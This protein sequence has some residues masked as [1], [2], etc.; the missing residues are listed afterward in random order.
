LSVRFHVQPRKDKGRLKVIHAKAAFDLTVS[1]INRI[2]DSHM[3]KIEEEIQKAISSGKF[4]CYFSFVCIDFNTV[5][6]IIKELKEN[7]YMSDHVFHGRV[8]RIKIS[9][10]V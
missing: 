10:Q 6:F 2:Y 4:E 8:D 9:W 3:L 7:G 1:R 5:D